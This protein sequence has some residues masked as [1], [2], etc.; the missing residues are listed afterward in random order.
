MHADAITGIPDTLDT[1][2]WR[3]HVL[4]YHV[5]RLLSDTPFVVDLLQHGE[6]RDDMWMD[7]P[8]Q[9]RNIW[10]QQLEDNTGKQLWWDFG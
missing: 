3:W 10:V 6:A 4:F 2:T 7:L 1:T 8:G 9:P 5:C